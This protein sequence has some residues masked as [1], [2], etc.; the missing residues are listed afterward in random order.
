MVDRSVDTGD[1]GKWS[2]RSRRFKA[3]ADCVFAGRV[4]QRYSK[5]SCN[6]DAP[7]S[8]SSTFG[9]SLQVGRRRSSDFAEE[10]SIIHNMLCVEC[11][12]L[13]LALN[14]PWDPR[15]IQVA[16]LLG[17]SLQDRLPT[18]LIEHVGSTAVPHCD[19][20]GIIDLA[21]ICPEGDVARVR[22]Y[23]DEVGFQKQIT[24][25]PFP[26]ERPMRTG[27]IRYDG[28]TFQLHV[29]VIRDDS[30]EVAEILA[31]REALRKDPALTASYV[32]KK[33]QIIESG[34]TD[35]LEYCY[36]KGGF[37]QECL[38]EIRKAADKTE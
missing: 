30:V 2:V 5:D 37:I 1:V 8:C 17:G 11:Y 14:R 3:A 10:V 18:V 29:H 31:F 4:Q 27:A 28:S 35:A 15:C 20:K 16:K 6:S 36:A 33:R 21:V 13:G 24:H 32:D 38:R 9:Y 23:L 26:K 25:D 22:A 34:V 19:G 7:C 12:H